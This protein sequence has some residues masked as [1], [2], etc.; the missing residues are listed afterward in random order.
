MDSR[1]IHAQT[2]INGHIELPWSPSTSSLDHY[3]LTPR[4]PSPPRTSQSTSP[5]PKPSNSRAIS[6]QSFSKSLPSALDSDECKVNKTLFPHYHFVCRIDATFWHISF[7]F[8]TAGARHPQHRDR[9]ELKLRQYLTTTQGRTR[10]P[11]RTP[12]VTHIHLHTVS[13]TS[14][15]R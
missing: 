6:H 11:R 14:C 9:P 5:F 4:N 7:S 15:P 12:W 2:T 10:A 3:K 13:Q 8:S 1:N